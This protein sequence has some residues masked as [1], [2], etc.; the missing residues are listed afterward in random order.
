MTLIEF[1]LPGSNLMSMAAA[2]SEL[3]RKLK[4]TCEQYNLDYQHRLEGTRVKVSFAKNKHYTMFNM[5]WK[6]GKFWQHRVLA[7]IPRPDEAA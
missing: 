4:E 5:V 1:A 6:P 3:M 7:Q 2:H